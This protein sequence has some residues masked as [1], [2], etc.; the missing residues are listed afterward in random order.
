MVAN[1]NIYPSRFVKQD[2]TADNKVLQAGAGERTIGISQAGTLDAPQTGSSAYAATADQPSLQI[3]RVGQMPL[4][5]AGAGG[6]A[7]GDLLKPDGD[8]K[9]LPQTTDK[10]WYGARALTAAAAGEKRA[11]I[12]EQGYYAA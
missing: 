4:L 3:Y 11:V 1:G 7:A 9:G 12:V 2:A 5:E 8:G 6:W 10:G